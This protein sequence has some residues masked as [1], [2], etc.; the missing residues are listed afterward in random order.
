MYFAI[1]VLLDPGAALRPSHP[2][3]ER[4][5]ARIDKPAKKIREI[6]I[7]GRGARDKAPRREGTAGVS[8]Y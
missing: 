5:N 1:V 6:G 7:R 4:G 8:T 2:Q 3:V